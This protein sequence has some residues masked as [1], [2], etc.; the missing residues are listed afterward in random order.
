MNESYTDRVARESGQPVAPRESVN[1][2]TSPVIENGV[3][4]QPSIDLSMVGMDEYAQACAIIRNGGSW[5]DN[6]RQTPV[7][8]IEDLPSPA[9]FAAGTDRE[10]IV[11]QSYDVSMERLVRER[12]TLSG[13]DP[14]A[15]VAAMRSALGAPVPTTGSP[16]LNAQARPMNAPPPTIITPD[17]SGVKNTGD[18]QGNAQSLIGQTGNSPENSNEGKILTWREVVAGTLNQPKADALIS[19]GVAHP[20]DV[21]DFSDAELLEVPDITPQDVEDL[22]ALVEAMRLAEEQVGAESSG[23]EKPAPQDLQ[24]G[25]VE[26]R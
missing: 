20:D 14:D 17:I 9:S 5:W 6:K 21:R 7:T 12:A 1:P 25:T 16:L 23:A 10:H 19:Y 11:L 15:A 18:P 4:E 24:A 13:D 26:P 2:L 22:R 8:R 3:N